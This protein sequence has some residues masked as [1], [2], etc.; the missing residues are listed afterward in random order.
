MDFSRDGRVL[1]TANADFTIKLWDL[2]SGQI[3]RVFRGHTHVLYKAI[4]SPDEKL[5]AS[6]SQDF[7]A[8]IWDVAS[9]RELHT[10]R[11]HNCAVKSVAFSPDG[12]VLASVSNDG[13]VKVW[14]VQTGAELQSL[15]HRK[16]LDADVSVYSVIFTPDGKSIFAGNGDGTIST[17]DR[18]TGRETRV[19]QAHDSDVIALALSP[20]KRL[21][22]SAGHRDFTAKVWDVDT[23]REIRT[24]ADAQTPGSIEEVKTVAFSPD[25]KLLAGSQLA[26][27]ARERRYIFTR[28]KVWEVATGK[29]ILTTEGHKNDIGAVDFTRD[30]RLLVSGGVDGLINFW[31]LQNGRL[32]RTLTNQP[33][34]VDR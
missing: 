8:R 17:W 6:C 2:E 1:A 3:F 10:L 5:L 29:V 4:F 21:L 20:D 26:Y 14:D 24:F 7:T 15:V 16:T 34:S 25:N 27:D 9:G 28:T 31:D 30:G 23:G 13:T 11:G 12:A 22:A 19:W 33:E 18:E 32:V